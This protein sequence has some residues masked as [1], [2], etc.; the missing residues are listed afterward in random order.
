MEESS[1]KPELKPPT[2]EEVGK[3]I[4][5][6]MFGNKYWARMLKHA[7]WSFLLIKAIWKKGEAPW[8][9]K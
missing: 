5:K 2:M 8:E 1:E 3:A 7:P 4:G 9:V 6:I